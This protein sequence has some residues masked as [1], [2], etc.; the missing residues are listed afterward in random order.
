[1]KK[2]FIVFIVIVLAGFIHLNAQ[3]KKDGYKFNEVVTVKTTPVKDQAR[4]GTCWSFA[5]ISFIE[6][7]LLRMGKG[8]YDLSEMFN[9]RMAYPEKAELYIRLHGK[10]QFSA[11]GQAH[12]V[13]NVFREYGAVPEKVY[14]GIQYGK[15]EH[16][17]SELDAVLQGM[18]KALL[19]IKK[20]TYTTVWKAA[21]EAVL[22]T[23]LGTVPQ[24]FEFKGKTYTP[25]S[26][27]ESLGLNPD[28]Y[29][30]ITSY[31]H[32]PF[33]TKFILEIPDNWSDDYYYNLPLEELMKVI[34]H[35]LKNGYSVAWDG[36]VSE[37]TFKYRKNLALIIPDDWDDM[38]DEEQEAVFE[39]PVEE[40]EITQ[41]M[42]QKTF[43]N[44]ST[45][46][47]HL[48]HLTGMVKDQTGTIYYR[49]KNSWGSESNEWEGF[50]N[51]SGSFVKLK[52][53]A[54]MVHKD[55]V[56]EDIRKKLELK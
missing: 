34:D 27:A 41:E 9:V 12:D 32:H 54:I 42:R 56:P 44:M 19:K 46:D 21:V 20:R 38:T 43:N 3:K 45:T 2:G 55:A 1:M 23:Y 49:T 25:K 7:E 22:D 37:E 29:I 15:D 8:E 53:V 10:T 14:P 40:K 30:E 51:M 50:F 24:E 16:N 52:T 5:A 13:M 36:D 6:T 35:A 11:G 28:N 26:F 4:S 31:T 39:K 47:D 18:L 48:M 33:Y 17:H